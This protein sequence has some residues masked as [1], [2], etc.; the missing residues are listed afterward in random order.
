MKLSAFLSSVVV[1]GLVG[2]TDDEDFLENDTVAVGEETPYFG[3]YY[4]GAYSTPSQ[5]NNCQKKLLVN[6]SGI[7]Y[8]LR[9]SWIVFNSNK[10]NHTSYAGTL[11][12]ASDGW[13]PDENADLQLD[14]GCSGQISGSGTTATSTV[15]AYTDLQQYVQCVTSGAEG[16]CSW[17]G[18][19]DS[20]P[21]NAGPHS[22]E[23]QGDI[24]WC[25]CSDYGI[26]ESAMVHVR[27]PTC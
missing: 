11:S 17:W 14:Q 1:L 21:A 4:T 16:R 8:F 23:N 22:L 18:Y 25:A 13:H 27:V 7:G 24:N 6:D 19:A 3:C 20:N 5:Y 12:G 10:H 9:E 2:C 26:I 15:K